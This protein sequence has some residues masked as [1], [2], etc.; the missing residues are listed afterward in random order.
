[1]YH[2]AHGLPGGPGTDAELGRGAGRPAAAPAGP[3]LPMYASPP[4]S[5]GH[6]RPEPAKSTPLP[7]PVSRLA[8]P[9]TGSRQY[10]V[11][12]IAGCCRPN[13]MANC[14]AGHSLLEPARA[15]LIPEAA[16]QREL[17]TCRDPTPRHA[18]AQWQRLAEPA[19]FSPFQA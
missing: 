14:S 19:N 10:P 18:F 1:M 6:R 12:C 7:A 4:C 2:G 13:S 15:V 11:V 9:G 17:T 3:A 8:I 5:A 16:M